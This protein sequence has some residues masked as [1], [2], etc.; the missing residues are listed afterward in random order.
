MKK[1]VGL[2]IA[3]LGVIA[4]ASCDKEPD[5]SLVIGVD[6]DVVVESPSA[7]YTF[8]FTTNQAWTAESD[9]D[10]LTLEGDAQ[11]FGYILCLLWSYQH[12]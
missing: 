12:R 2:F 1:L 7:S 6:A 4:I 11:P 8:T 9:S 5:P 10:W 3:T